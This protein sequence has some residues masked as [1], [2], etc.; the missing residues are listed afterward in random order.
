VTA[1][2]TYDKVDPGDLVDVVVLE[3]IPTGFGTAETDLGRFL[4]QAH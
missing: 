1:T 3:F 4:G 2:V